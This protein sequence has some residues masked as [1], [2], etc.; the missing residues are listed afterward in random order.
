[1]A[2]SD[3]ALFCGGGE[4][5]ASLSPGALPQAAPLLQL[6]FLSKHCGLECIKVKNVCDT[7]G[8][9]SWQDRGAARGQGPDG[10]RCAYKQHVGGPVTRKDLISSHAALCLILGNTGSSG[11][12]ECH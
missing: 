1:M 6:T 9:L 3:G 4:A 8:L 5:W 2:T 10:G 12:S 7:A 11:T